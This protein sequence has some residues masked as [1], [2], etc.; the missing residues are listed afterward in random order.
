[1]IQCN[2]M[3]DLRHADEEQSNS[4]QN[5]PAPRRLS[6]SNK[7]KCEEEKYSLPLFLLPEPAKVSSQSARQ[8]RITKVDKS[9][10]IEEKQKEAIS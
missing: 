3:R 1:M 10:Y 9:S 4:S 5:H 2:E 7:V 6:L 8:L